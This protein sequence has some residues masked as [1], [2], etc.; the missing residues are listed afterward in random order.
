MLY[1]GIFGLDFWKASVIFEIKAL[2]F[3]LLQNFVKA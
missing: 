1:F 3:V 2:K